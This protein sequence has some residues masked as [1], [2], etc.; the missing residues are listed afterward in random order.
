MIRNNTEEVEPLPR[1]VLLIALTI[2]EL[3]P[4]DKTN[5]YRAVDYLIK[6]D[7]SYNIMHRYIPVADEE[8]KIKIVNFYIGNITKV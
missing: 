5:F 8:W 7:F 4:E 3:I 6:H 1:N 2:L